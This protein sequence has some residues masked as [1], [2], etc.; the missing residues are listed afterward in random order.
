ML[1]DQLTERRRRRS[2]Q[3]RVGADAANA[4]QAHYDKYMGDFGKRS[5]VSTAS[6]NGLNVAARQLIVHIVGA[7][8]VQISPA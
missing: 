8:A 2:D 5:A 1:Q 7:D 3:A 4:R 6:Q